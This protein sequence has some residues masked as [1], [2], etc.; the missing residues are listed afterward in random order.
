MM[1]AA[2]EDGNPRERSQDRKSPKVYL[3]GSFKN[4]ISDGTFRSVKR[5]QPTDV[6]IL[7]YRKKVENLAAPLSLCTSRNSIFLL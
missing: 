2:E 6:A 3:A 4:C 1:H 7:Q 5:S